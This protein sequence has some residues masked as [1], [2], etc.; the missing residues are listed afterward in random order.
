MKHRKKAEGK[1]K[2]KR[3]REG[4]WR[5]LE[6]EVKHRRKA[7]GKEKMRWKEDGELLVGIREGS[8]LEQCPWTWQGRA[9]TAQ[10]W[11]IGGKGE[12][13][14]CPLGVRGHEEPFNA[15]RSVPRGLRAQSHPETGG[16]CSGKCWVRASPSR[17]SPGLAGSVFG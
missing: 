16:L 1:E 13:W 14:G 9:S 10:G 17:V 6:S 8:A 5:A 15:I 2:K 7:E 12:V 3:G 4:G 11:E